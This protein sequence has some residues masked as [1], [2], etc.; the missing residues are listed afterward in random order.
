MNENEKT[1][2]KKLHF[3][4]SILILNLKLKISWHHEFFSESQK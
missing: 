3:Y 1:F 4:C 2:L